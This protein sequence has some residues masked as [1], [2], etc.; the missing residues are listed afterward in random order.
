[1]RCND[2]DC[3]AGRN[4]GPVIRAEGGAVH[5][6]AARTGG[7]AAASMRAAAPRSSTVRARAVDR[8]DIDDRG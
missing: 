7:A 5:M 2:L 3:P 6:H 8:T 4:D 1:M